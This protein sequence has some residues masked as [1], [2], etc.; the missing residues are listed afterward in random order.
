MYVAFKSHSKKSDGE[1]RSSQAG[2]QNSGRKEERS[3][4]PSR[5]NISKLYRQQVQRP[6]ATV[7]PASSKN[8]EEAN[9][10]KTEQMGLRN[11]WSRMARGDMGEP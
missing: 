4:S 8:S 11:T 6:E 10:A 9:R 3:T 2:E 5:K 1:K 7:C